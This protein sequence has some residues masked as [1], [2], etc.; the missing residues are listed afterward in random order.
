MS[1]YYPGFKGINGVFDNDYDI[2]YRDWYSDKGGN[3]DLSEEKKLE[4]RNEYLRTKEFCSADNIRE[5]RDNVNK[6]LSLKRNKRYDEWFAREKDNLINFFHQIQHKFIYSKEEEIE[7]FIM[8]CSSI[9]EA[10]DS[11][12][13]K[14]NEE[15]EFLCELLKDYNYVVVACKIKETEIFTKYKLYIKLEKE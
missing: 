4:L 2:G 13:I 9:E 15:L 8:L 11:F 5:Y 3:E 1:F 6:L 14:T 12:Y 7:M 10:D